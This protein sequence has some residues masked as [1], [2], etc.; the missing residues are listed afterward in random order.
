[1]V[2]NSNKFDGYYDDY[3]TKQLSKKRK[4]GNYCSMW[5]NVGIRKMVELGLFDTLNDFEKKDFLDGVRK[6]LWNK[7]GSERN[8]I[9][10]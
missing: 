8:K 6:G 5:K 9:N 1:M 3:I 2:K 10:E 4:N 7:D